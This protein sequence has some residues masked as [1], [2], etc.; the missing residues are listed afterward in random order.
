MRTHDKYAYKLKLSKYDTAANRPRKIKYAWKMEN[1]LT[2]QK[3][4]KNEHLFNFVW[5][6]KIGSQPV[7]TAMQRGTLIVCLH[8]VGY[9]YSYISHNHSRIVS[10]RKHGFIVI[11]YFCASLHNSRKHEKV[12]SYN[13]NTHRYP[14]ITVF[15]FTVFV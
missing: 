4:V 15:C 11:F 13:S 2:F 7:T 3:V 14:F 6:S 8:A 5:K 1:N 9:F 10:R 12:S